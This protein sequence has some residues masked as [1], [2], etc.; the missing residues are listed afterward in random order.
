MAQ[1]DMILDPP[2]KKKATKKDVL[3][4]KARCIMATDTEWQKIGGMAKEA[5]LSISAYVW[6]KTLH[7]DNMP[8]AT[9]PPSRQPEEQQ[10]QILYL[11]LHQHRLA[12][13]RFTK[14]GEKDLFHQLSR[15]VKTQLQ[16]GKAF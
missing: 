7:D 2:R 11:L 14:V 12:E 16:L 9:L 3:N 13:Y 4:R 15:D 1:M 5:G 10:A 6:Q 8:S